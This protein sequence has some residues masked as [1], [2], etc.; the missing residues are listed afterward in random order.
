MSDFRDAEAALDIGQALVAGDGLC[1]RQV[2]GV[3]Q[4][5]E[6]S[7]E[8]FRPGDGLFIDAVAEPVCLQI[9]LEEAR[10]FGLGHGAGE[11]A[12]GTAVG[13][14][15]PPGGLTAILSIELCDHFPGHGLQVPDA[16]SSAVGLV[17][18]SRK[19]MCYD[20]TMV[21]KGAFRQAVVT[22]SK[23]LE[24]L[25]QV[26]IA[27]CWDGQDELQ[28]APALVGQRSQ[29]AD[30]LQA[31]KAAVCHQDD[32]LNREPPQYRLQHALQRLCLADIAG[33]H[34]V[35]QR[36]AV[37]GLDHAEHELP[38]DTAG[39]LV[40]AEGTQIVVDLASAMDADCGQVIEHDREI[41]IDQ[42][43]DLARQRA[44]DSVRMIHES[45]HGAQKV[46][47]GDGVWH[48]G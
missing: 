42:G 30:I 39:F 21:G 2:W 5:R 6:L 43:P 15:P 22:E 44:F 34:G 8:E 24:G 14:T 19:I 16:A 27:A 12:V 46:L 20:Q 45:I 40:H 18:G 4:Q 35:H 48:C 28:L 47:V 26:A 38:G 7:V 17:C 9:G 11:P 31:Q 32:T 37:C 10:Q 3:G 1:G 41:T 25:D 33:V 13:S 29:F 36:Q 23:A